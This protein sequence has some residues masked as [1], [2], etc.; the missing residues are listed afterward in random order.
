MKK[1]LILGVALLL[2]AAG[3][4]AQATDAHT[5]TIT[6]TDLGVI[7]LNSTANIS[8]ATIAPVL[9]GDPI[10]PVVGAETQ[11][12]SKSL[13][14][15]TANLVGKTRHITVGTD[16]N[17]PSGTSLSVAA[18]VAAG[19]GTTAGTVAVSTATVDLVTAI[20][21]VATGRAAGNGSSLTYKFWV[22]NP[23]TLV[24]AVAPTVVTVT[25][26]LTADTF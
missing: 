13:Y 10:G 21:S 1:L 8:F 6:V 14:Y 11:D 20:G 15:T 17:P 4:F 25:Y 18:A 2:A 26:T 22:S 5:V 12:T 3:A 7:G 9:P 24:A 16:V 23:A 19:A